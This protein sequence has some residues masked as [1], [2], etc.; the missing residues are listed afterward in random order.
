MS[1]Q[2]INVNSI[3]KYDK[4]H[5]QVQN[6]RILGIL[7]ISLGGTNSVFFILG[8]V[9]IFSS[10]LMKTQLSYKLNGDVMI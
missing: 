9:L 1:N 3:T 2:R 4:K 8:L 5:K 10:I 6:M 7:G